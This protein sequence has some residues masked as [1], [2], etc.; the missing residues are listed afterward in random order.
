MKSSLDWLK[1]YHL[2]TIV[3]ALVFGVSAILITFERVQNQEASQLARK[4]LKPST[5]AVQGASVVSDPVIAAYQNYA[6]ATAGSI[7]ELAKALASD[8]Q[9][10]SAKIDELEASLLQTKVPLPYQALHFRLLKLVRNL[11]PAGEDDLSFLREQLR[12]LSDDYPWLFPAG[13]GGQ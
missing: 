10:D 11:E 2:L 9:V 8:V 1:Q 4:A 5:Q 3:L 7:Q 13:S 6:Q 12:L